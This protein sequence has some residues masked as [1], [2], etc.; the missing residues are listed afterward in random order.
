MKDRIGILRALLEKAVEKCCEKEV[1]CVYSSGIDSAL[2]TFIASKYCKVNAYTVG[3]K[4][5]EDI[6]YSTRSRED[7][8]YKISLVEIDESSVEEILPELVKIV[9][10]PDPLKVSVGVPLY[11]AAREAKKDGL[12]VV[13]SGQGGDEL[14]GGY[15]RYLAHAAKGD[16]ASLKAAMQ[17]DVETAYID[18]LDR[19]KA[20]FKAFGIDLRFPYMDEA[21]G[22][23]AS[24]L[25]SELKI[26][27]LEEGMKE[28]FSCVDAVDKKRFI[29]KYLLRHLA[30]DVGVPRYILD[31]K[32]KAA[33]YGSEAE[34]LVERIARKNEYKNK[35]AQAGRKDYVRMYLESLA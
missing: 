27:E 17:K 7:A 25:P 32:K 21:F 33:Q 29:R 14:F 34:K 13:L 9:G 8:D 10:V 11:F 4:E 16:H 23:Y 12:S 3:T 35:A 6:K 24:S 15:N 28:E 19:D 2:I 1:G 31:R 20:I 26:Y 22:K 18:N 30:A 5:S